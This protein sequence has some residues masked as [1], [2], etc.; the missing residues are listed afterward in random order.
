VSKRS[1]PSSHSIFHASRGLL[2]STIGSFVP[3]IKLNDDEEE[4]SDLEITSALN[5]SLRRGP[6]IDD[7]DLTE[8]ELIVLDDDDAIPGA[9][10]I[11]IEDFNQDNEPDQQPAR[12]RSLRQ[13][14]SI[15]R[16]NSVV[17]PPF[18]RLAAH[19]H[20][21]LNLRPGKTVEVNDGSFLKIHS[22]IHNIQ[23]NETK[24]RGHR[25]ERTKYLNGML[26]KTWNEVVLCLEI[27]L[28]DPRE[29]LEQSVT[30]ISLEDITR[31][32]STRITNEEFPLCRNANPKD[33]R[34]KDSYLEDG[35]LTARW[36]YSCIFRSAVDRKKQAFKERSLTRFGP[37]ECFD[38]FGTQ[39]TV[40]RHRW[41]VKTLL[42]GPPQ[43]ID[44]SQSELANPPDSGSVRSSTLSPERQLPGVRTLGQKLTYGDAFSGAGGASRGAQMAGFRVVWGFDFWQQAC[45]TW[46]ANFPHAKI[47][48]LHSHEFVNIA[49]QAE[50]DGREN[51]LKVDV[52]HISAPCQPFSPAHTKDGKNDETNSASLFAVE[53]IIKA[54]KPRIV[55]FEQTF[56][57]THARHRLYF[58]TLIN[59][60]TKLDFSLR[61]SVVHLA[62]WGLPQVRKRLIIIASCP[63]EI[64][65]KIPPPTHS[66]G[67]VDGLK[68]FVTV[69]ET[70]ADI[71]QN[72]PNHD[73]DGA[74][75]RDFPPWDGKRILRRAI[76]SDG[77]QG[78]YHPSG[79]RDFTLRE[80][81]SLQS[82]PVEHVFKGPYVKLQIAKAVPPCAGM[83]IIGSIKEELDAA[84]GMQVPILIE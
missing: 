82:F 39:D 47:Y 29:P 73:V 35:G 30:E 42:G 43:E 2:T 9:Q 77:G 15:E 27:D 46:Q 44:L 26:D 21:D 74:L 5:R 70:I 62:T 10:P 14:I 25:L 49:K 76:C 36:K 1:W 71:P 60:F 80:L 69:N 11:R 38:Q 23:T 37:E 40:L 31:L 6:K 50:E 83:V 63:G 57:I 45:D 75:R 41:Q 33:F 61:W 79:K 28:D 3:V 32:R 20:G 81:A 78:N 7:D 19:K 84:D 17:A 66:E 54:S 8:L 53:E 51:P 12:Q 16:R 4:D 13:P 48:C 65:P 24:L 59:M 72:A 58:N 22:I 56:G 68:P 67:G 34:S 18:R 55:T 64:L 52:V